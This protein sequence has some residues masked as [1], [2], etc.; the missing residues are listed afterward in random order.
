MLCP[1]SRSGEDEIDWPVLELAASSLRFCTVRPARTR[2]G[3]QGSEGSGRDRSKPT[4]LLFVNELVIS[5]TAVPT[6][7]F[8]GYGAARSVAVTVG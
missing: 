7:G 1:L 4:S 2:P 8:A 3:S 6:I 5:P